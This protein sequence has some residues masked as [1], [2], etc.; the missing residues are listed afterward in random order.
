[1]K[2]GMIK[3]HDLTVDNADEVSNFYEEVAGWSK[4]PLSMGDYN[5]YVMKDGETNEVISGVCHAK[6]G[7]KD[8]PSC[9]LM[10]ITVENLDQSLEKCKSLGGKLLGEKRKIGEEYYCLI[11]DPAGAYVMLCG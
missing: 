2:A 3:W 10:Y 6:G 7:N 11:Q 8:L 5:D 9:W 1:M 4:E